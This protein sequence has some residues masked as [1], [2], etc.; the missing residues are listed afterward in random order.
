MLV[1]GC[2]LLLAACNNSNKTK[3]NKQTN[4][5]LPDTSGI[6][7]AP[8]NNNTTPASPEAVTETVCYSNEGLKYRTFISI[9]F[10]AS[11]AADYVIS[12]EL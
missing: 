6:T 4:A 5:A 11:T 8:A 2:I 9:S 12:E 7:T 10:T 1:T 3:N